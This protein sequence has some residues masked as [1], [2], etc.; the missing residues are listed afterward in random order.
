MTKKFKIV[1]CVALALIILRALMPVAFKEGINW[2]LGNK[3]DDYTG[4]I[5]DFDL[6]LWRGN[7]SLERLKIYQRG[8]DESLP[9]MLAIENLDVSLAWRALFKGRLLIDLEAYKMSLN[10]A[11]NKDQKKKQMTGNRK[12]AENIFE[13][14]V[15]FKIERMAITD[16]Q[17]IFSN[18]NTSI[19][20]VF[21]MSEINAELENIHNS[22]KAAEAAP[23]RI[24]ARAKIQTKGELAF[25]GKFSILE[26]PLAFDIDG[27]IKNMHLNELNKLLLAYV[28]VSFTSGDLDS[29]IEV[30]HYKGQLK[31]YVKP[32]AK[33]LDVVAPKEHFKSIKHFGFELASAAG[34][35]ILRTA[36]DKVVATKVKFN[37]SLKDPHFFI[38]DTFWTAIENAFIEPLEPRIDGTV[39]IESIDSDQF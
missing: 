23:S 25:K 29:Y 3:L 18:T 14:L 27:Q 24:S 10:L 37:G 32:F 9:P 33:N 21:N 39:Q 38:W 7:Y 17:L 28:P 6:A 12:E 13:T 31:G 20:S 19:P 35:L 15:P 36:K 16:S 5:E 26:S 34:N 2:Y 4:S 22:N 30:A 11:D 1:L 8:K